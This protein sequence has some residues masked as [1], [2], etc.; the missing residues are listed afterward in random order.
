MKKFKRFF[1]VLLAI[2]LIVTGWFI[3]QYR[4]VL[5]VAENTKPQKADVILV[6]G[7][8]VWENGPSPALKA[9]IEHARMLYREGYAPY[10]ILSGGQGKYGPSEAEVMAHTLIEQGISEDVLYLEKQSTNTFENIKFSK[11]IMD[12]HGFKTALIVTDSFHLKRSILLAKD[13]D[14]IPFGAPVTDSVLNNNKSLKFYYTLREV[15]ALTKYFFH[16]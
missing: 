12:E 4:S 15:L 10:I 3:Y 13:H 9:R 8:A 11:E 16:L 2:I 1:L 14:I 7:A 6:L 5:N